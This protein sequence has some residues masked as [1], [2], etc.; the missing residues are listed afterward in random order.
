MTQ[1][2]AIYIQMGHD[3]DYIEERSHGQW[4][5][6]SKLGL[7]SQ[8]QFTDVGYACWPVLDENDEPVPG[9]GREFVIAAHLDQG[10]SNWD[11][12]DRLLAETYRKII[13]RIVDGRL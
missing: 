10:G 3:I 6:L 5:I 11:A 2:T 1:D 9:W 8:G 7:G 13:L 4:V 12:R